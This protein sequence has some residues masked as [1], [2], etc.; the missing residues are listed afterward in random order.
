MALVLLLRAKQD[1]RTLLVL[2]AINAVIST[3]GNIS[4]EAHLGGFVGGL[5]LGVTFAYAPRER[6][7]LTQLIVFAVLWIAM[8]AAIAL[9]TSDLT[10]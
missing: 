2:L 6:K 1:V 8:I 9:R 5:L 10:F 3:Q 7:G 4:W